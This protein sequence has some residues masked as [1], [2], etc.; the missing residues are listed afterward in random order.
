MAMQSR[1]SNSE[2]CDCLKILL[3]NGFPKEMLLKRHDGLNVFHSAVLKL[4]F[5]P[6]KELLSTTSRSD[7]FFHKYLQIPKNIHMGAHAKAYR[8]KSVEH[9]GQCVILF[10]ACKS[11]S[12][13]NVRWAIVLLNKYNLLSVELEMTYKNNH[14]ILTQFLTDSRSYRNPEKVQKIVELILQHQ[15]P[16]G[17]LLQEFSDPIDRKRR[18]CLDIALE[19]EEYGE[20]FSN[21]TKALLSSPE[22]REVFLKIPDGEK[23]RTYIDAINNLDY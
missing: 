13:D 18:N 16:I 4:N 20:S 7:I 3:D 21:I 15:F 5:E 14:T 23:R 6:L 12:E 9:F 19:S 2:R 10:K 8:E 17:K 22:R 1:M 11:G